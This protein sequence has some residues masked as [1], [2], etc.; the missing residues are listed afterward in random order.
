MPHDPPDTALLDASGVTKRYAGVTALADAS[1]RVGPGEV[2]ALIGENGAG[3]ST[4]IKI[5]SGA[6]A[7]DAGQVRFN[8]AEHSFATPLAARLGGISVIHQELNLIP[9]L[10]VAENIWL[11]RFPRRRGRIDW[12]AVHDGATALMTRLG[13]DVDVRRPLTGTSTSI[14]QMTAIARAISEGGRL[15]I[16]D[17]PTSSLDERE[18][19]TLLDTIRTLRGQGI[20]I[21]FITHR[22]NEVY[23][24]CDRITVLRDGRTVRTAAVADLPRLE[25]VATMI[26]RSVADLERSGLTGLAHSPRTLGPAMLSLANLRDGRRLRGVSL[27][28]PGDGIIG[29]AGLLGSGRTETARAIFGDN[30]TAT[31]DLRLDGA[32]AR[33]ATPKDAI[34][35]GIGFC[36]EDRKTEGIIPLL[37]VRDNLTL[38]LLPRLTRAGVLNGRRQREIV[39]GYIA[40]LGIKAASMD[41]PI[42]ELS[43]GNQQKVLLARWL[44]MNPRLLILDEPT[45]G[46]DVGAKMEIQRLI[47]DL[48]DQGLAVLMIS[49]ELDELLEGADRLVVLREGR[50]VARLDP[51]E[52][53][54]DRLIAAMAE[55]QH[56]APVPA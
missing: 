51:A 42:R 55:G 16:M 8:G 13:L 46:I 2:H 9:Y 4:L 44:C 33:I 37:S 49:S 25:L 43:G 23:E 6:V 52:M 15:V 11:G 3:K 7:R 1:L 18:V 28:V 31:G 47:R 20:S 56:A 35:A 14:Q 48:A 30:P 12:R 39:A 32:P 54:E 22:L 34:R 53:T 36:T 41:Q 27:E 17:E 19:A 45:R 38:A 21:L 26:G 5:L 50:D 10:S 40:K 29:L 24:V